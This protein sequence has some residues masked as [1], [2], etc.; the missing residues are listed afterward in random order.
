MSSETCRQC[1][2]PLT[3]GQRVCSQCGAEVPE[4]DIGRTTA[5]S[6]RPAPSPFAPPVGEPVVAPPGQ[7]AP[8]RTT[9]EGTTPEGTTPAAIVPE[10]RRSPRWLP[11]AAAVVAVV[12]IGLLVWKLTNSDD[13]TAS[14]GTTTPVLT[15]VATETTVVETTIVETTVETTVEATTAT[16][17]EPTTVPPTDPP[18]TN[19]PVTDPPRPPWPAP[20]IPDPPIFAGPG[21]PYAISDPLRSGMNSDEPTQ[22]LVFAQE[23]FNKMTA[24]D[25]LGVQSKF[26]FQM[27]D[28]SIVPY[29]FD[30]QQ[31]W[32]TAA[33]LSLLLVDATP[34]STGLTGYD[35]TVAVVANFEGSTSLL[36]GHLYSDPITDGQVVQRG[37]FELLADGAA[38]FMPESLLNDPAQIADLQA[39][40]K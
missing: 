22:Y 6:A 28:G 37:Q 9:P 23:V 5:Q 25:W 11:L 13:S 2:A 20:P 21:L 31:Q 33:R 38:P 30:M 12:G 10:P 17:V 39:R 14:P 34:D 24:G 8:F 3:P 1:H 36:C 40:C 26:R 19:P 16:T 32:P 18:V 4:S 29:T 15:T 27:P 35:L 7:G